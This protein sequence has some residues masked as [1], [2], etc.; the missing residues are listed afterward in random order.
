MSKITLTRDE[1]KNILHCATGHVKDFVMD[2]DGF[3]D[4]W[5]KNNQSKEDIKKVFVKGKE[6]V[7]KDCRGIQVY[8]GDEVAYIETHYSEI[9]RGI[10]KK[11]NPKS[12][13]VGGTTR[14]SNQFLKL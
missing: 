7:V 9:S 2:N 3:I 1:L 11:L 13:R 6:I 14:F 5:L 8:P 4:D 12:I 10:I